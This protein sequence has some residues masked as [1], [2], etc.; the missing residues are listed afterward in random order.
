V[1]LLIAGAPFLVDLFVMPLAGYDIV[2]GTKWL[3]ALG[4]IV[5]DLPNRRMSF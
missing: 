5:W 1:P 2:L 4:P 3:E